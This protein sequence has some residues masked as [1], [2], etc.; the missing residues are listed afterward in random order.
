MAGAGIAGAAA[1]AGELGRSERLALLIARMIEQAG[2]VAAQTEN[3]REMHGNRS[4][5]SR[6]R[7][8]RGIRA[9]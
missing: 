3:V 6:R 9:L 5:G 8:R 1:F 2:L 7:S 4:A